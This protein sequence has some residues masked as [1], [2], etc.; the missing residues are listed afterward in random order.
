MKKIKIVFIMYWLV[1][2]GAEQALYDLISLLDKDKFDITIFVEHDTGA[3]RDKFMNSG[4][5]V[6]FDYSCRQPTWNPVKKFGNFIK[7]EKV[8]QAWTQEGRGM[9]D[10][11]CPDADIIVSYST[12]DSNEIAFSQN[13]KSVLYVHGDISTNENYRNTIL[14]QLEQLPRY[15][16]IVCVSQVAAE[17]FRTV[18]GIRDTVEMHYNPLNSSHVKQ[19][20]EETV[21]LPTDE[22][23]IC[24][25]GRLAEEKGFDR[26]V[27]IHR[28]LLDQ[29]IRHKL[30]LVGDGEDRAL[31]ERMVKT[32]GTQDSVILAGYQE[33]PYPYMRQCKFL[34][35]SSYTE[36]LPVIAM[37]ALCLG[38]P[39]VAPV[40]SVR[41]AFGE[42]FCG[43]ITENDT[44]SLEAG[45]RRMLT[46]EELYNR[47]KAG[48]ERRSVYFDGK[49][50]VRE[51]EDMFEGLMKE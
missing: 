37:E 11:C 35:N 7:K 49:R 46:D 28:R 34:V 19:L 22:P 25:V 40:P 30:V 33:N 39:I 1:C 16:K 42:E 36:G 27:Y 5:R 20:A 41:E 4:V 6:I 31:I 44:P 23:L 9:M 32:T 47:A 21:S 50:M 17:A 3:W 2:G 14:K 51:I 48:A 29:G 26:L 12:W 45:I 43:L 38:V 15:K 18:T 8:K 24:A 13:A 10:V